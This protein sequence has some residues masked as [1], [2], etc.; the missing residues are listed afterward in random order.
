MTIGHA[1]GLF[2]III[3]IP[4]LLLLLCS[5]EDS[6][7]SRPSGNLLPTVVSQICKWR[8]SDATVVFLPLVS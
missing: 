7:N 4:D 3:L 6:T 2:I 1:A 5:S 8:H